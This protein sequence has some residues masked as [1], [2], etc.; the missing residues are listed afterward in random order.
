M[1]LIP[2]A[3]KSAVRLNS[4]LNEIKLLTEQGVREITLLG[5]NVNGYYRE[6]QKGTVDFA[7]LLY[8][9]AALGKVERIRYTTSHPIEFNDALVQAH[10]D[11]PQ[12]MDTLSLTS[13]K[14]VSDRIFGGD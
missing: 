6:E 5:Q 13:T 12:L 7:L 2:E 1:C 4:I 9:I 14:V 10:A 3:K 8:Y 11:I